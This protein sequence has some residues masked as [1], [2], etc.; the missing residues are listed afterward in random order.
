MLEHGGMKRGYLGIAGQPVTP[1][2]QRTDAIHSN[3]LLVTA[4]T[5]A[6]PR[7]ALASWFDLI[8]ALDGHPIESPEDLLDLLVGDRVGRERRVAG[9]ARRHAA[10]YQWSSR[11]STAILTR[12]LLVGSPDDHARFRASLN[13]SLRRRRLATLA[14][15]RDVRLEDNHI[16]VTPT[17]RLKP[18]P[19]TTAA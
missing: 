6:G 8:L 14:S 9:A 11:R 13:R 17:S 1:E 15:A 10:R 7:P 2:A 4:V 5:A 3:T 18:A 16:L 12:I 19:R